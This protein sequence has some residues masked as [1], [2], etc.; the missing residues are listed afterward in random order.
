MN[1]NRQ[2]FIERCKKGFIFELLKEC[3]DS[4]WDYFLY[5]YKPEDK[6]Y[7]L[8]VAKENTGC[9]SGVFGSL[10]YFNK[11]YGGI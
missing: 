6:P 1:E 11:I 3:P 10:K 2:A 7:V 9:H 4:N 8:Y 5:A